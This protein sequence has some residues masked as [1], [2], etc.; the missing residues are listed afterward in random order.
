MRKK[1][2]AKLKLN[3]LR[4]PLLLPKFR[5]AGKLSGSAQA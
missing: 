3:V 2:V 4:K 1:Y 5:A